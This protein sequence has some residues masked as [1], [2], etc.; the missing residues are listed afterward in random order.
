MVIHK[1]QTTARDPGTLRQ[2]DAR[3]V[4]FLLNDPRRPTFVKLN[5]SGETDPD[6]PS[7]AA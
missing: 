5:D 6:L 4:R 3:S 2:T 7:A 1:P